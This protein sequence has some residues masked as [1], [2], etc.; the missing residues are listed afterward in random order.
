MNEPDD[1]EVESLTD[2]L[3][4]R[5][6][7]SEAEA[8]GHVGAWALRVSTRQLWWSDE[9]YR[10]CGHAPEELTPTYEGF[11]GAVHPDDRAEVERCVQAALDGTEA[12]DVAHRMVH[13]SGEVRHVREIGKVLRS[14]DGAPTRMLGFIQDVTEEADLRRALFESEERY[15]L[16]AENAWDVI[17]TMELDGSISYVSPA[18]ERVRGLTPAE[19]A[20]Q[21]PEEMQPPESLAKGAEYYARLFEAI[22]NGTEVPQFHGEQEYYRKD[23]SIMYGE[24]DVVPQVDAEGNVLR[25]LGVTRDISERREYEERLSR[26]AVTDPLTGV[27]NRRQGEELFAADM[28]DARRY[29]LAM[30]LLM[31][32]IDHFKDINDTQGHQAGDRVLVEL[33]RRLNAH[34]RVSDVLARWGGEEFVILMRHS[35]LAEAVPLAEKLRALIADTSFAEVGTVTISIGAAELQPDDDFSIWMDRADRAMYEAKAAGRNAVRAKA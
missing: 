10:I 24:L 8:L 32:D 7:L 17:W 19:A 1:T 20:V 14:P 28:Y 4:E 26:L 12:L 18:V 13:P 33:C 31:L 16:L 22:A 30:S 11:F 27:W 2:V 15:R 35:T 6:M 9:T 34:L 23:G 29:G 25:I 5:D 3:S 21:P